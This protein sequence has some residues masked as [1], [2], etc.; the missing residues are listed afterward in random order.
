MSGAMKTHAGPRTIARAGAMA[1][2]APQRTPARTGRA[3][4]ANL[5]RYERQA[6]AA[7]QSALRG[8]RRLGHHLT[9]APAA[10]LSIPASPGAP[11]ADGLR[12]DLEGVFDADLG[13]VR[14]HRDDAAQRAV[15]DV[16]AHALAAGTHVFF[17][18][19]RFDPASDTGRSLLVHELTHVL[20]QSGRRQSDGRLRA[21]PTT[22]SGPVMRKDLATEFTSRDMF[23]DVPPLATVVARHLAGNPSDAALKIHTREVSELI[24]EFAPKHSRAA[25]LIAKTE[26]K[27]F[28]DEDAHLAFYFDCLK[29]LGEDAAAT[30]LVKRVFPDNTAF[31]LNDFYAST[32]RRDLAWLPR[33]MRDNAL[34][35]KYWMTR[36]VDTFRIYLFAPGRPVQNL[37]ANR[38]FNE[39]YED[40]LKAGKDPAA[41]IGN[42]RYWYALAALKELDEWRLVLLKQYRDKSGVVDAAI[43]AQVV[44]KILAAAG[45]LE[46]TGTIYGLSDEATALLAQA[47]PGMREVAIAA[48]SFWE[49]VQQIGE[50]NLE[51]LV[52]GD[53]V[54]TGPDAAILGEIKTIKSLAGFEK[55][56]LRVAKGVFALPGGR[57][58]SKRA[59]DT[60]RKT[61]AEALRDASRHYDLAL[62]AGQ[63]KLAAGE[64]VSERELL[65]IGW[66]I[67]LLFTLQLWLLSFEA[68]A[69]KKGETPLE[70]AA[71]KDAVVLH[72]LKTADF[73]AGFAHA[74]G[75]GDLLAFILTVLTGDQ[76]G[77]KESQFAIEP[78][79][80]WKEVEARLEEM[81]KDL[82]AG[83][84]LIGAKPLTVNDI[85]RFYWALYADALAAELESI[86][87]TRGE[88]FSLQTPIINQ[89]IEAVGKLDHPRRWL[90][91]AFQAA[92]RP[93]DRD[94]F[95][96]N[97]LRPHPKYQEFIAARQAAGHVPLLPYSYAKHWQGLVVWTIPQPARL[98]E[99]L[100]TVPGLDDLV[101][102]IVGSDTSPTAIEWLAT[103]QAVAEGDQ[104]LSDAIRA[105]VAGKVTASQ[106]ALE[107][108]ARKATTHE[109]RVE[110]EHL[111]IP[112][113]KAFDTS[114]IETYAKSFTK[115]NAALRAMTSFAGHVQPPADNKL[116]L[117]AMILELAPLMLE[118]LGPQEVLIVLETQGTDR[119]DII[120]ALLPH[121]I[122]TLR[123]L[124]NDAQRTVLLAP[125]MQVR[126]PLGFEVHRAAIQ[127]L[128]QQ[129]ENRVVETQRQVELAGNA[130][131]QSLSHK[132]HGYPLV[133][134]EEMHIEGVAYELVEVLTAFTYTPGIIMAPGGV[135]WPDSQAGKS[136]LK[137]GADNVVDKPGDVKLFRIKRNDKEIVVT[138]ADDHLLS[139]ITNAVALNAIVKQLEDLA[140]VINTF[141]Q[142]GIEI[143]E[144]IP[145]WGQAAMVA[146]LITTVVAFLASPEF[147]ELEAALGGDSTEIYE[148]AL[149]KVK[150]LFEPE[151]L[152]G[153]FLFG[154]P[155]FPFSGFKPSEE[156]HRQAKARKRFGG[157]AAKIGAILAR[158]ASVGMRFGHKVGRLHDRFEEPMQRA[159]LF[160]RTR[161]LLGF[162]LH[163]MVD[164][165]AWLSTIDLESLELG[166]DFAK[167]KIV[168][169]VDTLSERIGGLLESIR[170]LELPQE[171]VPLEE[172]IDIVVDIVVNMLGVKFKV[173]L[174]VARGVLTEVGAWQKIEKAVAD[175]LRDA[176][177][178]PNVLWREMVRDKIE[179]YLEQVTGD[180]ADTAGEIIAS[181]PFLRDAK[182]P[183]GPGVDL[184]LEPGEFP[185][186]ADGGETP[187]AQPHVDEGARPRRQS[188]LSWPSES[189]A[190]L[191][192][193]LLRDSSRRLGHDFS[194]VRLH[195]GVAAAS[196][197][198]SFG[199]NAL[200]S[201]SHIYLRRGLSPR[202]GDGAHVFRHELAHVL[203][204]TGPRPLGGAHDPAPRPGRPGLGLRY[205]PAAEAAANQTAGAAASRPVAERPLA[206]GS[207]EGIQPV[208]N[209]KLV[210]VMQNFFTTLSADKPLHDFAEAIDQGKS[211]NKAK[212]DDH[213][214]EV[215]A[216]LPAKLE[217][218]IKGL[219]KRRSVAVREPFRS[220]TDNIVDYIVA[221]HLK[222]INAAVAVLVKAGMKERIVKT[223]NTQTGK[224]VPT[225]EWEFNRGD[226]EQK[227]TRYIF[228]RSGMLFDIEFNKGAKPAT[229]KATTID[230]ADP[231]SS[232]KLIGL[233][234]PFIGGTATLWDLIINNTWVKNYPKTLPGAKKSKFKTLPI[235]DAIALYKASARL[236]LS[237][238]GP[239]PLLYHRTEFRFSDITAR[240]IEEA[241]YPVGGSLPPDSLPPWSDYIQDAA[242]A[243]NSTIATGNIA[244][245]FG[246]YSQRKKPGDQWGIERDS[247][248]MVQFLLF[249]Y[250]RNKKPEKPFRH[251]LSHYPGVSGSGGLV[252]TI[253]KPGGGKTVQVEQFFAG[254]G[255]AMPTILIS[256]HAHL[257]GNLHVGKADD[258]DAEESGQGAVVH[259][260]FL[261]HLGPYAP[262]M[263]DKSPAKLQTIKKQ[264]KG[265]VA[266]KDQ[267][268]VGATPVTEDMLQKAI[269][270][271]ACKTYT[272]MRN[273]IMVKK[274]APGL[275]TREPEYYEKIAKLSKNTSVYNPKTN[276]LQ[277]SFRPVP[278]DLDKVAAKGR[279]KVVAVL[280]GPGGF[281]EKKP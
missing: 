271:A 91:T 28:T 219:K 8:G 208:M 235:A 275:K 114:S 268:K 83:R 211:G 80:E 234:L 99:T 267:V 12:H 69:E 121:L 214:K 212:L 144:L 110:L 192:A 190:P 174:K 103:M 205:D 171:I 140:V 197:T 185:D 136:V 59:Y 220:E 186:D 157:Q 196:L 210:G 111:I 135:D 146:R 263:S 92:I 262:I 154:S 198:E 66:V 281:E 183:Q 230:L 273:D 260:Q 199:A 52:R 64:T 221:N 265:K 246:T 16:G 125:D 254:R 84:E 60:I 102:Q 145:G 141:G 37:D 159:Q 142:V 3:A 86:L 23:K 194:H 217:E 240:E 153:W 25:D 58:P 9:P 175:E 35:R 11:L 117:A 178:D 26:A 79:A 165:F 128:R 95:G 207:G 150:T 249:E 31:G 252:K 228:A 43:H 170:E 68:P 107:T 100:K 132:G 173:G 62:V 71:R 89:A 164:N 251:A 149:E 127:K 101:R 17:G 223:K 44:S 67:W 166:P 87:K 266:P 222:E 218:A 162:V 94:L 2:R 88:D 247:H 109:R 233:H 239:S 96:P 184:A 160:V 203:Q 155:A 49:R 236:V 213:A 168:G 85:Q 36:F 172:I 204:Q 191:D 5:E 32:L 54:G 231:F 73:L 189:G 200:T 98:V 229:G 147:K 187:E 151:A 76:K 131:T 78:G 124:D 181:V 113:W 138:G 50:R 195:Q 224:T 253:E 81:N 177:M 163:L 118:K 108:L 90:L 188:S 74:L 243:N 143:F 1:P 176:K 33:T 51:A 22:G 72:R 216:Q 116:Q 14:I 15:A 280:E 225:S 115:P 244:L 70:T 82:D 75:F 42:E 126:L 278:G 45:E 61:Q 65:C 193:P 139:E 41:L 112:L 276:V 47:A 241:A 202:E 77:Q 119:L 152:W 129:T 21:M 106:D 209:P 55:D 57:T 167:K 122:G 258:T 56:L 169:E 29:A 46:R 134:G 130:A 133:V 39:V 105:A 4:L 248:H 242:T 215:K 255:G 13:A 259:A 53:A 245:R 27:G 104:A 227:L 123:L 256:K 279:E 137:D 274:L 40:E 156:T 261:S 18:R 238:R 97:I 232:F 30:K 6:D 161:P 250:F 10:S 269:Y 179:P 19:D 180:F 270:E 148:K 272:W 7:A 277:K 237:V 24:G 20:Q 158:L 34:L 93:A 201:G 264:A 206:A 63:R 226:F 120:I 257:Y 48:A 38:F 182:R